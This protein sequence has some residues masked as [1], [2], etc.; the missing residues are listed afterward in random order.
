MKN[1]TR[2]FFGLLIIFASENIFI[3]STAF[4]Q[5]KNVLIL[6]S[7][8][9]EYPWTSSENKGFTQTLIKSYLS[10][11][12][13]FSTEYLDTKRTVFNR[14]YTDFFYHYLKQ[15]YAHYSPDLIF[16]SD[17]NAL[18][19]LLK[20]KQRLFESVPVVFC[21]VNNFDIQYDLDREQYTG[22]FEKKEIIPNLSLLNQITSN[23]GKILFLGDS[24]STH[25]AIAQTII[26]DMAS[27]FPEIKYEILANDSLSFLIK[28]L[29]S[30]Q[31]GIIFLT[32]IGGIKDQNNVVLPLKSTLRA[33]VNAGNYIII[34]ME[35]VYLEQGILGGYVTNGHSQGT[36]AAKLAVE[37]LQGKSPASIPLVVESPNQY[38]FNFP[39]LKKIGFAISKLPENAILLNKPQSLYDM[40]KYRIW[41]A[42]LFIIIQTLIILAL[43]QNIHKR[44]IAETSLKKSHH[45]LE[46]RVTQRTLDLTE[47]N[48]NL[49]SEV[50]ERQQAEKKLESQNQLMSTLLEN[51]RVG[52][53]M[54]E[55]PTGNPLLANR[56]ALNL[57]GRGIMNSADKTNLAEVYQAFKLSTGELYPADEMPIVRGISGEAHSIDDMIVVHPDGSQVFLEVFGSPVKDKDGTVIASLVSFIDITDR[58]LAEKKKIRLEEELQKAQKMESI[59]TLAGGI[60][61]DFNNILASLL[62]FTELALDDATK[63]TPLE[64][65]LQEVYTAG[66]RARDLV[67]QIL[68]FAR[69]SDEELKPIRVDKVTKEVLQF[70][71]SSIP[72][73]IEIKQDIESSS[74]IMGNVT[75]VHQILMNLCTNAA[76]AMEDTGGTLNVSLKDILV[77]DAEKWEKL[78]LKPGNYIELTVS[79]TG[80]GIAPDIIDA[81]FEPYFTTKGVAKGT[82]MGLA[83]THGIVETYNGKINVNSSEGKGTTFRIYLPVTTKRK[84]DNLY[85]SEALP[86]GTERILFVDDEAPIAKMGSLILE[87]LGYAVT[88]R[89]SSVEAKE[90]F[91]SKPY[92][93]DLVITDMTMPNITGDILAAGLMNIRPDIP[94]IMCTGYNNKISEETAAEIGIKAFAYKP[95][96]KADLSKTVRKV[97]DE[98]KK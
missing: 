42:I 94:V 77:D 76:H 92:D 43:M 29:Q 60:A 95:I 27:Q 8:H 87:R 18:S 46:E 70:I 39:Q 16:C 75:Q 34:S 88:T 56:H 11:N 38:M 19:F 93:F 35:D 5:N 67:K 72:T 64:E 68:A 2:L 52:V 3:N 61:H 78:D 63:G 79:D 55:A 51:L 58:K 96:V 91:R 69:Q 25:Q 20:F 9:Q 66:I 81:I 41:L 36:E 13:N 4:A 30:Y 50:K 53:F 74:L 45:D 71:R 54:V 86:T 14:E 6:H 31:K 89:T 26:S 7:Y 98:V 22:V 10:G 37:I 80:C 17:D 47:I 21:G 59:G 44:R 24:S 82:G 84:A 90:L 65:N 73:T 48:K 33:I 83:L 23:P 28:Q 12:I 62:G 49:N 57:L 1:S 85:V 97:L 40:Y 15:K 32:T